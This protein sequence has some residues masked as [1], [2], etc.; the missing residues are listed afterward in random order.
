AVDYD[1]AQELAV[2][3]VESGSDGLVVC[4][5]TGESPVLSE[6]EKLELFKAV[7]GAV[8]GRARVIAGTG[9]NDTEASAELTRKAEGL[10]VDGILAVVPY[11]NRP[12]QEGLYRHFRQIAAATD[13]PVML[14]NIPSRTGR[15][16]EAETVA[17][18]ADSCR[19]ITAI[20]ESSGDLEQ[21][22]HI[23][24]LT[25]AEFQIYSGDDGL[26]LPILSIGGEGVVSVAAHI[27]GERIQEMIAHFKAG[28]VQAAQEVHARLFPLFQALST[29][30]N[31]I[32]V[33]AARRLV[34]F[35]CGPVRLP[36]HNG[37]EAQQAA[38]R[39][40]LRLC[41]PESEA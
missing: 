39:E 38:L 26:T 11:Y 34:G 35:D 18:L 16:L 9:S 27:A 2:R 10:G 4:G 33:K 32:P 41:L 3:L 8:R 7:V 15:N 36:L 5:T 21:A 29:T 22:S 30:T 23:R 40:A 1:R 19:N 28:R 37:T 12:P 25:S 20:K 17:R 24:V 14:Y 6:S 31:P 13:L